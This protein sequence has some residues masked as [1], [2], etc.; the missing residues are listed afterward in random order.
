MK[1]KNNISEDAKYIIDKIIDPDVN[2]FDEHPCRLR[3][4][5][6]K[7]LCESGKCPLALGKDYC[8]VMMLKSQGL[9]ACLEEE[10]K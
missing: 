8:S 6:G 3:D 4:S 2:F 10:R 7:N 9:E 5:L 1:P